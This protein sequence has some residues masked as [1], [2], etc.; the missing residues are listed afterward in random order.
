MEFNGH[1]HD[2]N[3]ARLS[4]LKNGSNHTERFMESE[5]STMNAVLL[6]FQI[7]QKGVSSSIDWWSEM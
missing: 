2:I 5:M 7:L 4:R 6:K 1:K 3:F